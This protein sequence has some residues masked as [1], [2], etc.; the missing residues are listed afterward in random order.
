MSIY[1]IQD[2]NMLL[3]SMVAWALPGFYPERALRHAGWR[4]WPTKWATTLA[5][6]N[7]S[8]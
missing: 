7:F 6:F 5:C 8:S 4:C 3:L 2:P 1:F